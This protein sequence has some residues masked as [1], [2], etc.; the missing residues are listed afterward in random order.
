MKDLLKLG[1]IYDKDNNM[2]I[3]HRSL[4]K[5]ICNPILRLFDF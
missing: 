4:L 1:I 5:V 2:I 3:N